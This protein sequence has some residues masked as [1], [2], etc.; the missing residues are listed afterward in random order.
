MVIAVALA[1]SLASWSRP[2]DD[3]QE[4]L[5]AGLVGQERSASKLRRWRL[6]Q[7]TLNRRLR[8]CGHSSSN[9][10]EVNI[11]EASF[12]GPP[13]G[14]REGSPD[15]RRP[16][17]E[18]LVERAR[19]AD[20]QGAELV[21]ADMGKAGLRAGPRAYHGLVV[22][23]VR[24][25][26]PDGALGA[27]RRQH[28]SGERALPETYVELVKA[29]AQAGDAESAEKTLGA[30]ER[31]G[32]ESS[33]AWLVLVAELFK[34]NCRADAL[35]CYE[36]GVSVGYAPNEEVFLLVIEALCDDGE[37]VE[38]TAVLNGMDAVRCRPTARHFNPVIKAQV[39][40]W[41][42]TLA[43]RTFERM[44]QTEGEPVQPDS[45]S[46]NWLIRGF[47]RA[48]N[49]TSLDEML[50]ILGMMEDRY[51]MKPNSTTY[52]YCIEG[53]LNNSDVINAHR[54]FRKMR[55]RYQ[56]EQ[57]ALSAKL[58]FDTPAHSYIDVVPESL[59]GLDLAKQN[60]W[61]HRKL[62]HPLE[63]N[64]AS[65]PSDLYSFPETTSQSW[66]ALNR[67]Q[68]LSP[69]QSALLSDNSPS[70]RG[71]Q[72]PG[73][74]VRNED[75]ASQE[76]KGACWLLCQEGDPNNSPLAYLIEALMR[77]GLAP[78]LLEVLQ[79]MEEDGVPLMEYAAKWNKL[80]RTLVTS[81]VHAPDL[82]EGSL[83]A[84]RRAG[85]W[86][87]RCAVE[88]ASGGASSA[89]PGSVVRPVVQERHAVDEES[90]VEEVEGQEGWQP[91]PVDESDFD[92]LVDDDLVV[93]DPQWR[94]DRSRVVLD[95]PDER[96]RVPTRKADKKKPEPELQDWR[97]L[98]Q[99]R[100]DGFGL[101]HPEKGGIFLGF[102]SQRIWRKA[103]PRFARRMAYETRRREAVLAEAEEGL[104]HLL[105]QRE[106][107][108][109][110]SQSPALIA[111][112]FLEA[113]VADS[114][115]EDEEDEDIEAGEDGAGEDAAGEDD[116]EVEPEAA[117]DPTVASSDVQ[118]IDPALR[119]RVKSISKLKVD[120]LRAELRALGLPDN[121]NRP[122]L[123]KRLQD[124]RRDARDRGIDLIGITLEDGRSL[125]KVTTH[126]VYYKWVH[127]K[128]VP[129]TPSEEEIQKK[130]EAEKER[131]EAERLEA[132]Q[133]RQAEFLSNVDDREVADMEAEVAK[134][135]LW[136]EEGKGYSSMHMRA[137]A[138]A[139]LSLSL[140]VLD[141]V[142][143]LG[144]LASPV[145]HVVLLQAAIYARSADGI[146]GALQRM[147][148]VKQRTDGDLYIQAVEVC[149]AENTADAALVVLADMENAGVVPPEALEA[150]VVQFQP[151]AKLRSGARRSD[152]PTL[153]QVD[154]E[155][156]SN[157]SSPVTSY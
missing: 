147:R 151:R 85:R 113:E 145:D 18:A 36:R 120:E 152:S 56:D 140:Q 68:S 8:S 81:W 28:A 29:Y 101:F 141:A 19:A 124:A 95:D 111:S 154:D 103:G 128:K 150:R 55:A 88:M 38:A 34:A 105:Q 11:T 27:M 131:L 74:G 148:A 16:F 5:S 6:R 112:T 66:R 153:V 24:A 130:K 78:E 49:D 80:G 2:C 47:A 30:M 118:D 77:A 62:E 146:L 138:E 127:G 46:F 40:A 71:S 89:P 26:D 54:S 139:E 136:V 41:S 45:E 94:L 98:G 60:E 4:A 144:Q 21:L 99:T 52:A 50:N 17:L 53:W 76:T 143:R 96:R 91:L 75:Q 42:P 43:W 108:Q 33:P 37:W 104:R 134:L 84:R 142:E 69:E 115:V 64:G 1:P 106:E 63:E 48:G 135:R 31:A 22:A 110:A 97:A 83:G 137:S 73:L 87:A 123:Y 86:G 57:R 70:M 79:A 10:P 156:P 125:A 44:Q 92:S 114:D 149:L 13:R 12:N 117:D 129:Y 39:N 132:Q 155:Q 20:A 67:L 35:R 102:G 9:R 15:E 25:G 61:W 93:E 100:A 109:L 157:R 32:Y 23:Y 72:G 126:Y 65:A 51:H 82:G 58:A 116:A 121:G 59:H 3:G 122:A 90:L 14:K 119:L 7:L 107:A 133:I